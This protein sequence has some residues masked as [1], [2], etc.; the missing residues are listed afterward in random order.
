MAHPVLEFVNTYVFSGK[1]KDAESVN[2][3]FMDWLARR[4]TSNRPFFAFLNYVDAHDPYILPGASDYRLGTR[5]ETLPDFLLLE[6]WESIDKLKLEQRYRTLAS[7]CYDDCIRYLDEQLNVLFSL[8]GERGLLERTVLI[9]TADHGEGFGEHDLYVHG[10][11]LY[12][13]EIHVPLLIVIPDSRREV[14]V[15]S[16]SVSLCDLPATVVDLLGMSEGSP[17]PG[18][19]L[20]G[21]RDRSKPGPLAA[22]VAELESP[23]PFNPNQGRSP[24]RGGRLI[25]LTLGDHTYI[26]G[27]GTEELFDERNDPHEERNLAQDDSAKPLL[28]RFRSELERL[29]GAK[30]HR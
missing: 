27:S 15:V 16:E 5:P 28:A 29:I 14:G 22:V 2:R 25:S 26:R 30:Q 20:V 11:S 13:S 10:E 6:N 1:R 7:D 8:L 3:S 21:R 23:N 19:S 12:R 24:A 17:F 18:Q 9:V 4:P